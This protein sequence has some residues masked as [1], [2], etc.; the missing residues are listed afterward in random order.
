MSTSVW[1]QLHRIVAQLRLAYRHRW[2][3]CTVRAPRQSRQTQQL[4]V[5]FQQW[6]VIAHFEPIRPTSNIGGG[7]VFRVYLRYVRA[8]PAVHLWTCGTRG[9]QTHR[10]SG[11]ALRQL[12]QQSAGLCLVLCTARGLKTAVSCI[13]ERLTGRLAL[14]ISLG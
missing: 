4:L 11:A 8:R 7:R 14:G 12:M 6:G 3:S 10:V 13:R 2:L 1:R 9:Q 5:S